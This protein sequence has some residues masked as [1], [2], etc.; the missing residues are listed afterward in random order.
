MSKKILTLEQLHQYFVYNNVSM[1]FN[2]KEQNQQIVV[3]VP[4]TFEIESNSRATYKDV[5]GETVGMLKMKFKVAHTEK[6][7]NSSFIARENMEKALPTLKY[8]PILAYIHTPEGGD[9]DFYAHNFEIKE[10]VDGNEVI[11]YLEKQVGCFTA[12]EP[13]LE[14]D[15]EMDKTYVMAYGMIPEGYTQAADIIR[16]K[17]GTKVSCELV[18]DELNYNAKDKQL[19]LIDFYFGGCTLLGCDEDGNPIG[20]GMEGSRTDI[21][22]FYYRGPQKDKLVETL[23]KIHELLSSFKIEEN[24]EKGGAEMELENVTP[25]E[26]TAAEEVV[27]VEEERETEEEIVVAEDEHP[28]GGEVDGDDEP[29]VDAEPATFSRVFEISHDDIRCGLYRLLD[30]EGMICWISQVFDKYFIAEVWNEDKSYKQSYSVEGDNITLVDDRVQVYHMYV[31]DEEKTSI[32]EMRTN[33]AAL[34]Q[35][36]DDY[37]AAQIKTEKDA[38]F[39]NI[40]YSEIKNSQE[41]KDL[42][43]NMDKY[44]VEEIATKC[45]LMFAAHQKTKLVFEETTEDTA[46]TSVRF[47]INTVTDEPQAYAG[48]FSE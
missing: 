21:A 5:S 31:T 7:R 41:F 29:E 27:V 45:D 19:E 37:D 26:E 35:F 6:N 22:D 28:E 8:R 36:K 9:P 23:D 47:N 38:I 34:K 13:Y 48:L 3:S 24:S 10:D 16:R 1:K 20:E 25:V 46:P 40:A 43:A 4:A 2:A 18:I 30:A 42:Q 11:E 15:E 33:Y 44:S 14:Y 12:D 39:A 32:E 17:N